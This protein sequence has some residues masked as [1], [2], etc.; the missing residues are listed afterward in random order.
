M[1]R[2]F[3]HLYYWF[4]GEP[5]GVTAYTVM[6]CRKN[7]VGFTDVSLAKT[8]PNDYSNIKRVK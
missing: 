2:V 7:G 8:N 1:K 3:W 5:E 6:W 4:M